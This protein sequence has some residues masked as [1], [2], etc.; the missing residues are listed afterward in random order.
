[1]DAFLDGSLYNFSVVQTGFA[2][3]NFSTCDFPIF[4]GTASITAI[5]SS[6]SNRSYA[7]EGQNLTLVWTYTLDGTVGLAQF[8]IITDS[9][10]VV[11]I[12]NTFGPGVITV[13]PEYQAR[14]RAQATNTRAE[15]NI[16]QVQR[17]D[18]ATYRMNLIPTASGSLSQLVV[19]IVNCKCIRDFSFVFCF[20]CLFVFLLFF[21][22]LFLFFLFCGK[23]GGITKDFP[24]T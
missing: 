24:A 20:V 19:V 1:M 14:F 17:E 8:N 23:G 22:F 13:E 15:L 9:G 11:L 18:E 4:P 3:A 16:V 5:I 6:P 12:G 7:T 21:V 10:S 2:S